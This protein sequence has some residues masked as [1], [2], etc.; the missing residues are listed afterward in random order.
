MRYVETRIEIR[1]SDLAPVHTHHALDDLDL[2]AGKSNHS[3][4]VTLRRILWKPENYDVA[5]LDLGCPAKVVV[6]DQLVDE[7]AFAVMQSRQHRRAFHFHGLH[8]E[9]DDE[10]RDHQGK[11]QIA[12]QQARF[13]PK[14][15]A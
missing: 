3:L 6:V 15:A 4:D 1:L 13:R 14:V 5:S 9:N 7:D 10:C 11:D 12:E 8:D 2:I